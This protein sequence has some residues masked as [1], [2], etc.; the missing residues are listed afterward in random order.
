MTLTGTVAVLEK[1]EVS[2][3]AAEERKTSTDSEHDS[4]IVVVEN[5]ILEDCLGLLVAKHCISGPFYKLSEV[6]HLRSRIIS[7]LARD[8]DVVKIQLGLEPRH[9]YRAVDSFGNVIKAPSE[10][11]YRPCFISPEEYQ[12][13]VDQIHNRRVDLSYIVGLLVERVDGF[14]LDADKRLV[15]PRDYASLRL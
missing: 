2:P 11:P 10:T 4:A 8:R 7:S 6:I 12:G 9:H 1:P 15:L 13:V 3:K 14:S 5:P